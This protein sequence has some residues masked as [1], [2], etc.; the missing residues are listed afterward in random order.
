MTPMR[1]ATRDTARSPETPG[2]RANPRARQALLFIAVIAILIAA[3]LVPSPGQAPLD[4]AERVAFDLQMNVLRGIRNRVIVDDIVLIGLDESTVASMPEPL[5][6]WHRHLARVADAL[7]IANPRA[8]GIDVVLP[9]RS[10]DK[11]LPGGDVALIRSLVALATRTNLVIAR[12]VDQEGRLAKVHPTFTRMLGD[13]RFGLDQQLLD[14]DYVARRFDEAGFGGARRTETLA[15]QIARGQGREVG[16]GYIDFSVGGRFSYL[17]VQGVIDW[18]DKADEASLRRQFGGRIVLVGSVLRGVDRWQL[19]VKLIDWEHAP[20]RYELNQPGVVIHAQVLR[21]VMGAGLVSP[22]QAA[23]GWVACVLA[24]SLVFARSRGIVILLGAIAFPVAWT[25]LSLVL[26]DRQLLIPT[27]SVIITAWLALAARG[28]ADALET[29]KEKGR[30]KQSFAGQVSPDVLEEIVGG[31]LSPGVSGRTVA[32]CV[33]FSDIRGFTALSESMSPEEV[34]LVLK[35]YFDRM[36][37]AVHRHEGT[38]DKFI[39]DGM[40]ILFG[41]PR[42]SK[43][44]CGHAVACALDMMTELDSL[45]AEFASEG[46]P[47]LVIGIGI[48]FGSVVVGNIGSSERHNYSAIGDAVN[49][50]ARIEGLT[51]DLGRKIIITDSVVNQLGD[52]FQFDPLGEHKLKGHSPVSVW[53]IRTAKDAVI[54]K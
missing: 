28:A 9:D 24:A 32:I 34:T 13:E 10:Y 53:G 51:K 22:L 29:A 3:R 1:T 6:L 15:G 30:L 43:D 50:A 11:L 38:V 19:P 16:A 40:M 35:R 8:V 18:L 5:A 31:G 26:V 48:N 2:A 4:Q 14:P 36:V 45:N 42:P 49:V 27:A 7:A 21:S 20:G 37:R 47:L 52:R 44:A 33:L 39:G 17:P 25:C 23:L 41:A 12:T 54:P 46:R